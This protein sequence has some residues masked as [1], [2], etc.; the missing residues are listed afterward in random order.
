[1]ATLSPDLIH[2]V[3]Q[4]LRAVQRRR[5]IESA[6]VYGSQI[7]GDAGEW[8]DIDVA[9]ISPDF[10]ADRFQER[11]N[12]MMLAAEIDDR[13]EPCPYAPEDFD[14]N[15]PLVSEIQRTGVRVM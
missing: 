13:I 1:M 15:D 7:R 3:E 8:S 10:S 4:F 9:I 2:A 12:L 14:I 5:R 6:Y 11:V